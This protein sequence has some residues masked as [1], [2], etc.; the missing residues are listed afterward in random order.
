MKICQP[1]SMGYMSYNQSIVIS[2]S[3]PSAAYPWGLGSPGFFSLGFALIKCIGSL[4]TVPHFLTSPIHI[5]GEL[6]FCLP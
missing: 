5:A 3:Q 2:L 6:G 4:H 1:F